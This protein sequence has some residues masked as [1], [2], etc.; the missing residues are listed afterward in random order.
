[1]TPDGCGASPFRASMPHAA[2]MWNRPP[3]PLSC[4]PPALC[5]YAGQY[6]GES[7]NL[8]WR[9]DPSFGEVLDCDEVG[10]G[11]VGVLCEVLASLWHCRRSSPCL[12]ANMAAYLHL[13][14]THVPNPPWP[15]RLAHTHTQDRQSYVSIPGVQYGTSGGFAVVFWAQARWAAPLRWEVCC[16]Q[17]AGSAAPA[18]SSWQGAM[19]YGNRPCARSCSPT[20]LHPCTSNM[21][22]SHLDP[23]S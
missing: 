20:E 1:M 23:P 16:A 8:V 12:L 11:D 3:L 4:A 22:R 17:F 15:C 13:D 14:T 2:N 6:E 18:C 5:S 9:Q 7:Q 10:R 19:H 21:H